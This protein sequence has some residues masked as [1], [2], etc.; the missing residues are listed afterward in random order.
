MRSR[1]SMV[2]GAAERGEL[3]ARHAVAQLGLV[4]EREQRLVAA[5]R[6]A[7]AGDGEHLVGRHERALAAARRLGEGAVVADVAAEGRERDEDLRRVRHAAPAGG[8]APG[9]APPPAG[10][11]TAR[12]AARGPRPSSMRPPTAARSRSVASGGIGPEGR[13]CR[14]ACAREQ[15]SQPVP[16][17]RR[18]HVLREAAHRVQHQRLRHG[19]PLEA[20]EERVDADPVDVLADQAHA[21]LRPADDEAAALGER[22]PLLPQRVALG[23]HVA[24]PP[25]HVGGVLRSR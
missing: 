18:Q 23:Q 22:L 17:Q 6:G 13:P 25:L 1:Y 14:P 15:L 10:R 7:G 19:R 8:V 2:G 4:A 16:S 20:A 21:R 9:A 5:G 24:L 12:R 11:R 3:L